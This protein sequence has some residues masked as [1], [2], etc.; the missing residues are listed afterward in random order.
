V[1]NVRANLNYLTGVLVAHLHPRGSR[2]ATIIDVQVAA[3][4]IRG[5]ELQDD[6]VLDLPALRIL[7]LWIA[8][9]LDFHP[10]RTHERDGAISWHN[11]SSFWIVSKTNAR[12]GRSR[13]VSAHTPAV[14]AARARSSSTTAFCGLG[15]CRILAG[16][17]VAVAH[18]VTAANSQSWSRCR[19]NWN[20]STPH[21]PLTAVGGSLYA[22]GRLLVKDQ[23]DVPSPP[24]V[25]ISHA[26]PLLTRRRTSRQVASWA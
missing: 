15:R 20:C 8:L 26:R 5:N 22:A 12:L 2:E 9:V 14:D 17:Q 24:Q 23:I 16:D 10:F 21:Q 18:N 4:D 13:T 1:F 11:L 19:Y 25:S 6:R 7:Q 3:T